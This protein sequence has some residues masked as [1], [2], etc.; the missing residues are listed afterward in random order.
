MSKSKT[1]DL[2]TLASAWSVPVDLPDGEAGNPVACIASTYTFHAPLFE[3][4][5]L[6][7]FLGLKF[8]ETEGDRPFVVEREQALA[9]TRVC[10]LTDADHY[11][12]S[13]SSLRWHQLPVRVP[14][15]VQHSKVV[16]LAW[17]RCARL[18]V[19]SANLTRPGYRRNREIAGT[20]DFYNY[21]TSAPRRVMLD[22]LAFL[23]DLTDFVRA[24]EEI[25][26]QLTGAIEEVRSRLRSWRQMPS[27]FTPHERPRVAFVGGLPETRGE[28]RR[29]PITQLLDAWGSRKASTVTVMTPFVGDAPGPVDKVVEQLRQLPRTRDAQGRLVVPGRPSEEDPRRMVVALP[30][31]FLEA[32]SSAWHV[33]PEDVSTYVVPLARPE[34]KVNRDLHAKGVLLEGESATLLLC[35]S[36]NFTPHGMGVG[37]ANAEANL[38]YLDDSGTKRGGRRL[39][40]RLPVDWDTDVCERAIWPDVAETIVDEQAGS[41]APLPKAFSWAIYDQR[42]ALLDIV[43]DPSVS[44]PDEWHLRWP[45]ACGESAPPLADHHAYPAPPPEG[46]IRV[47]LDESLR[48]V[49]FAGL[50]LEWRDGEGRPQNATL[51]V[52]TAGGESLLPPEEFRSITADGILECLLSGRDPAEW[53]YAQEQRQERGRAKGMV[54]DVDPLRVVDTSAYLLYR[55]RRFGAALSAMGDRL[56]KTVR[57]RDAIVYRLRQDPLGPQMLAEALAREWEPTACQPEGGE[58][59]PAVLLFFLGEI[60][61]AVAHLGR[62]LGESRLLPLFRETV[63]AIDRESGR[64]AGRFSP[65]ANLSNYLK[66]VAGKCE[67]LLV[68]ASGGDGHAG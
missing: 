59:D 16:V 48:G 47:Q 29:S 24:A 1:S 38:C 32:W 52:H 64:I 15:G 22:A 20:L 8:D 34:E 2:R 55:T 17:E 50:R 63:E 35:G 66:A 3:A 21:A 62:C 65:P 37:M 68:G 10:V 45:G 46:R 23:D 33:A 61:L 14:G 30:R 57:T 5:L 56:A 58:R 18:V 53:V 4:E 28:V 44:F 13:Q 31:R 51:P 12:V 67:Q 36:S 26:A 60:Q 42:A 27:D 40:D 25:T 41:D 7:R 6:P 54:R 9:T 39:E 11:D 49:N 43:V 19:S